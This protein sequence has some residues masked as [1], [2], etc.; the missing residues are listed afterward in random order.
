MLQQTL[1]LHKLLYSLFVF[2]I[3][4]VKQTLNSMNDGDLYNLTAIS[5]C[6]HN[7]THIDAPSHFI[8]GAKNIDNISLSKVIGEAFVAD[9]DGILTEKD[10]LDIVER[11]KSISAECAK[12]ILL[13]GNTTV[14]LEAANVL[15]DVGIDLIG[16]E[17]QTVGPEEAP[18]AVHKV[19]LAAEVVLL[20]GVR[21]AHVPEGAYLLNAAPINLAGA[22]GAPCRA[23]LIEFDK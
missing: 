10:A 14:S 16:N 5:M 17:S 18:M 22:E 1:L 13:K 9:F 2:L 3:F 11:A 6:A 20:E 19:L 15:A 23:I 4:S 8:N 12:R 7:G 21:L